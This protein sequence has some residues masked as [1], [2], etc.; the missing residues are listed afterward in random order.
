MNRFLFLIFSL[1][2]ISSVM[3]QEVPQTAVFSAIVRNSNNEVVANSPIDVR[4][5]FLEGGQYGTPVYCA[6]HRTTTNSFGSMVVKLNRDVLSCGCND[7]SVMSFEDIPWENGD[8]WMQ[9][10]YRTDAT[11]DFSLLGR[12]ELASTIYTFV[13]DKTLELID[14]SFSA[15][16][17]HD[18]DVLRYNEESRQFEPVTL[19]HDPD[20][21]GIADVLAVGNS[22]DGRRITDLMPPV[23]A[24]DAVTKSYL[25]SLVSIYVD[26]VDSLGGIFIVYPEVPNGV[27]RNHEYVDL[28]LPSGTMWATCNIGASRPEDCGNYYAWGETWPKDVYNDSTYTYYED[29]FT[30][31][32]NR[33]AATVNWGPGWRMPTKNDLVELMSNCAWRWTT[34][35]GVNGYIVRGFNGNSIFLPA[36]GYRFDG[37]FFISKSTDRD[38]YGSGFYWLSTMGYGQA[39]TATGFFL[40]PQFLSYSKWITSYGC[41]DLINYRTVGQLVRPVYT[42]EE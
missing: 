14:M 5:T 36:C 7:A 20:V 17:V 32:P 24:Q 30:L 33:D 6:V 9:V 34:I 38:A 39:E 16:G 27:H 31:Q 12:V 23:A 1:A 37:T 41:S 35:N 4:L 25:D 18:G 10:E 11:S 26:I 8:Y 15:E 42:P 2:I 13:A 21:S 19:V 22:A 28:G 40:T 29:A 3:A